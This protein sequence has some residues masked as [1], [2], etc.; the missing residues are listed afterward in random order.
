MAKGK[1]EPPT[2]YRACLTLRTPLR[3][4][5]FPDQGE[6]MSYHI[7]KTLTSGV[8]EAV[9][10]V[11]EALKGEGFGILTQI[12]VAAT[13]KQKIGA[14]FRSYRILGACNPALAHKALLAEDKI[15]VMLPCNVIVQDIGGGRVEVAAV[16]PLA[17]MGRVENSELTS[18][19]KDV[20]ERLTRVVGG[21]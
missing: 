15:G 20:A 13:L 2:A 5:I 6:S 10:K 3:L 16:N 12:D 17:A 11:T 9:A 1:G 8:D 7:T 21:L 4:S 18:I 19:A 14:D